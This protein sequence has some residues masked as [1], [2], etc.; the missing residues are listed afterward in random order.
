[1]GN[2]PFMAL[3]FLSGVGMFSITGILT[4]LLGAILVGVISKGLDSLIRALLAERTNRWRR[5]A[6]KLAAEKRRLEAQ[7]K[8]ETDAAQL[9]SRGD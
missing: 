9:S 3:T 2:A 4:S 7:L 1:M 6:K 8:G 5:E